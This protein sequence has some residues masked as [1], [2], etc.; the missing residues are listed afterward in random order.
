M[1]RARISRNVAS[2]S[3]FTSRPSARTL[4]LSLYTQPPGEI[5]Q[6]DVLC[7]RESDLQYVFPPQVSPFS[8]TAP[9]QC[10]VLKP[11]LHALYPE[12]DSIQVTERLTS[13]LRSH[14]PFNKRNSNPLRRPL[15]RAQY[16]LSSFPHLFP[17]TTLAHLKS[18][19]VLTKRQLDGPT[20]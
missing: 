17:P 3:G 8:P 11:V 14:R 15:P 2:N 9:P 5:I 18:H 12:P 19:R 10:A 1:V 20:Q 6:N 4:S 13:T 7:F 16:V